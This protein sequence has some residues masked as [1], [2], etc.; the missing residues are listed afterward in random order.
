MRAHRVDFPGAWH[1][2]MNRGARKAPIFKRDEH[3]TLFLDAAGEAV[4]RANLEVHAYSLMPNHF[5]LLVRSPDGS[6]S[7]GMKQLVSTYTR[8]VNQLNAWDGPMFRGRFK[9]Q[10]ITSDEY[11]QHVT[12]Y[13]HLNPVRANL[14]ASPDEPC[15]TSHR[16]HMGLERAPDWLS[17]WGIK[18]WFGGPRELG[19]FVAAVQNK[20][21]P[22]PE[23][24]DPETGM[25]KLSD[26]VEPPPPERPVGARL[27][28]VLARVA[29]VS[30]ATL[31]SIRT[32]KK[33]PAANPARRF[34]VL[35]MLRE[36]L[37]HGDIAS[38][39]GM[40]TPSVSA[41]AY[42]VRKDGSGAT[43]GAWLDA[44]DTAKAEVAAKK[45][46]PA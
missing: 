41:L 39:L 27:D 1:H 44:Y 20:R 46:T 9:S 26:T 2:V 10:L 16:A 31:E 32:A 38:A 5:H 15:W 3:C 6:L 25:F 36:G 11:L 12:A 8:A 18:R 40:T 21:Q 30:G 28:E 43:V 4:Q 33:G 42:R 45:K 7:R 35:A 22:V 37:G 23:A 13:I 24:L 17:L 19:K 14:V 29:R 34:A